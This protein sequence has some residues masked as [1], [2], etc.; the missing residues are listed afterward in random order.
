MTIVI[1]VP[2]LLVRLD[3]EEEQ[4]LEGLSMIDKCILGS[5]WGLSAVYGVLTEQVLSKGGSVPCSVSHPLSDGFGIVSLVL[6]LVL[7][8]IIGPFTVTI[9][10]ITISI[11]N[12]LMKNAP[13]AADLRNEERQNIFCMFLLTIIFFSTYITSMVICEVL[14]TTNHNL[15]S[16]VVIKFIVGTSHHLLGPLSI[17][18]SR[19]DILDSAVQVYRRGGTTQ[20]KSLEIT[21][22]QM[23]KELGLG[24][25]H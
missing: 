16:F 15:F 9:I 22:E 13:V 5:V 8:T 24:L 25:N 12:E 18:L 19:R 11:V 7:P 17:L 6:A 3:D 23:Q 10:H 20:S 2:I 4:L 14:F 1:V 21:A